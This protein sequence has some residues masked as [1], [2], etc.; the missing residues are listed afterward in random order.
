MGIDN[1]FWTILSTMVLYFTLSAASHKKSH[2]FSVNLTWSEI[3]CTQ[4]LEETTEVLGSNT[5]FEIHVWTILSKSGFF[6]YF[7][8]ASHGIRQVLSTFKLENNQNAHYI[9][10]E[11]TEVVLLP[12]F[13]FWI[14]HYQYM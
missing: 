12:K 10:E 3:K 6:V 14:L 5:W 13:V 7:F 8:E 9:W 1:Y 4:N 2:K 11:T